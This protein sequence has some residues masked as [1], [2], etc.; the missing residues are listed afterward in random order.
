MVTTLPFW[1]RLEE[2]GKTYGELVAFAHTIFALPF[3]LAAMLL[4]TTPGTWPA[5]PTIMWIVLAMVGA[6]TYAMGINRIVDRHIDAKNPR[7]QDRAIP[8]GRVSL[9]EAWGLTC[10]AALL[11]IIATAQLPPLC[12]TLLPLAFFILTLYSWMKRFSSL[13]HLVLGLALGSSAIGGWVAISGT[14]G[15]LPL[16]FGFAVLCWVMG[17]DLIYA[18]QDISVDRRLGLHSIPAAIGPAKTLWLS[19]CIH[20]LSIATLVTFG[21]LYAFESWGY[22]LAV[23]LMGSL[24]VYEH[25]LIRPDDFSR[26]DKAFFTINGQISVGFFALIVLDRF[27]YIVLQGG[28]S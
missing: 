7:T 6:R 2:R 28:L 26:V 19:R 27:L 22:W 17:F 15:L 20:G 14:F 11:L 1:S 9:A 3:A 21:M 8:A 5:W 24:L 18:C 13:S 12:M 10:V 23:T 4:A 25:T 16:C